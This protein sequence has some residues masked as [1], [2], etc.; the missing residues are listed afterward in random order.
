M[1]ADPLSAG[2]NR[3]FRHYFI[4]AR[5]RNERNCSATLLVAY[6]SE[7]LGR[8][9]RGCAYRLQKPVLRRQE[10]DDPS[11][12]FGWKA[13]ARTIKLRGDEHCLKR[14]ARFE[15]LPPPFPNLNDEGA[16]LA[17][18][19]NIASQLSQR[20]G[21]HRLR[22]FKVGQ[23]LPNVIFDEHVP[24]ASVEEVAPHRAGASS[25]PDCSAR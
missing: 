17:G 22:R 11:V 7:P 18:G 12:L 19:E 24:V 14:Q 3:Y 23:L 4:H 21:G 6:Q 2:E 1:T 5:A 25:G 16:P 10:T 9:A 13:D 20:P 15:D 8:Y